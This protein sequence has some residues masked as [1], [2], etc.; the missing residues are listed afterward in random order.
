MSMAEIQNALTELPEEQRATIAAWI[1]D[2]LPPHSEQDAFAEG[3]EEAAKR[4][5]E[6]DSGGVEALS[7]EHFWSSVKR[8]LQ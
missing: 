7:S 8:D 5:E 2:S 4:R 6:L 3:I 1:L